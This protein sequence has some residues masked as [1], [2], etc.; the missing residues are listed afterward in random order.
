MELT[1]VALFSLAGLIL[2]V[3]FAGLRDRER[4]VLALAV[5]GIT[6]GAVVAVASVWSLDRAIEA[7]VGLAVGNLVGLLIVRLLK[8]RSKAGSIDGGN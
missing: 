1:V 3:T 5:L 7:I 6:A 4:T 8:S 2:A